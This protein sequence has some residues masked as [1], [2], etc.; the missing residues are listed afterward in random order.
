MSIIA[1]GVRRSASSSGSIAKGTK[2]SASVATIRMRLSRALPS[3]VASV[4][5]SRLIITKASAS[6][7]DGRK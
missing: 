5:P 3:Q 6:T 4:E 2:R 7:S 1:C